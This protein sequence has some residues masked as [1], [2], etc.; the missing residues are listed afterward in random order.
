MKSRPHRRRVPIAIALIALFTAAVA[1]AAAP[2]I[3]KYTGTTNAPKVNGYSAPVSFTVSKNGKQLQKLQYAD[4]GCIPSMTKP[5]GNPY[6]QPLA[7]LGTIAVSGGKFSVK[8]VKTSSSSNIPTGGT[9]TTITS[10]SVTGKF[11]SATKASGSITFEQTESGPG[12]FTH[13]CAK[14]ATRKFTATTR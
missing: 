8:N 12:G 14:P 3:G 5:T 9:L 4:E 11:A 6:K 7:K 10:S 13:S 1:L 2:K